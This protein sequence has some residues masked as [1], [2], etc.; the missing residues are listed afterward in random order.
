MN[1]TIKTEAKYGAPELNVTLTELNQ[2]ANLNINI[3]STIEYLKLVKTIE[4]LGKASIHCAARIAGRF[5]SPIDIPWLN[6]ENLND[7]LNEKDKS[8]GY[9]FGNLVPSI[10]LFAYPVVKVNEEALKSL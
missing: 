8:F 5:K 1:E 7:A 10:K 2:K 3:D 9:V 4:N 6:I